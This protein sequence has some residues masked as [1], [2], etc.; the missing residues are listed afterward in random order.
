MK[1][2]AVLALGAAALLLALSCAS[3]PAKASATSSAPKGVPTDAALPAAATPAAT[4]AATSAP[5]A[6]DPPAAA[7]DPAS[8][9]AERLKPYAAAAADC[10]NALEKAESLS[11]QGKWKSAFQALEDFDKANADPYALA[12]KTSILLR[13]AVRSDMNRAFGLADLAEGQSLE[14]LRNGEGDYEPLAFDPPALADAQAAK[15]VS[16]PGILSN[17]SRWQPL[18]CRIMSEN[19]KRPRLSGNR[20]IF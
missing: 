1:R 8:A 9:L 14:E 20:F 5:A 18:L 7:A 6:V 11:E 16:A 17:Q 13:G 2:F 19:W 10:R 4:A 15:G 3:S 12:M